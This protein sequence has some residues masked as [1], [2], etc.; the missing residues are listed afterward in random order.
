MFYLLTYLLFIM[1]VVDTVTVKT[2]AAAGC[3]IIFVIRSIFIYFSHCKKIS[4]W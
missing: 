2:A 3:A 1:V 4:C